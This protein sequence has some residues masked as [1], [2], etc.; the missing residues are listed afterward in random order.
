MARHRV[1]T[2]TAILS[3][4]NLISIAYAQ[5]ATT[6]TASTA[7]SAPQN[8]SSRTTAASNTSASLTTQASGNAVSV[9]TTRG[10]GTTH[11]IAVN[12]ENGKFDPDSVLADV[13]EFVAFQFYPGNHSV[14][15]SEYGYPCIPY[16]L[17]ASNRTGRGFWSGWKPFVAGD[18]PEFIIRINRVEPLW[19]Y[20]ATPGYCQ[21]YSM[22]GVI[23]PTNTNQLA[24][25][26]SLAGV[27][28]LAL[29]PGEPLPASA[30]L[31]L[32]S[33][34]AAAADSSTSSSFS[35]GA[36]AGTVVGSIAG[37]ASLL[38]LVFFLLRRRKQR[39][40]KDRRLKE[41]MEASALADVMQAKSPG[42]SGAMSPRSAGSGVAPGRGIDSVISGSLW[43]DGEGT[44]RSG[45]HVGLA[46]IMESPQYKQADPE[47]VFV[48][49]G[50]N[51]V[52]ELS[53]YGDGTE[54]IVE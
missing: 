27:A 3:L 51:E 37:L 16:G 25:Q 41:T 36:I 47:A 10:S 34:S 17:S 35:G 40:D 45:G 1:S 26:S 6:P 19:Y 33:S 22:V 20:D 50:G 21:S 43:S 28:T 44:W 4:I 29:A 24:F 53:Q 54:G 13:G 18:L 14:A 15:R 46:G 32:N 42:G 52:A 39:R 9:V 12:R 5:S 11:T 7:T 23:N 48:E 2:V 30:S 38:T 31:P 49:A 8:T